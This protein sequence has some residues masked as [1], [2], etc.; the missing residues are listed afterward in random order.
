MIQML[1]LRRMG[2]KKYQSQKVN[3]NSSSQNNVQKDNEPLEDSILG[4]GS[5]QQ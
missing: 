1:D 5:L 2:D 3:T 4:V